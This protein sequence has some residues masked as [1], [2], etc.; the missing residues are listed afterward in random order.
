MSIRSLGI[1]LDC[2]RN[3]VMTPKKVKEFASLIAGM[4]YN[5]LLLY[6][7]DTYEIE[8]EPFFGY[9]RGRYT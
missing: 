2:S 4:G 9:M 7:E 1:M 8:G 6:T 3:A 5:M